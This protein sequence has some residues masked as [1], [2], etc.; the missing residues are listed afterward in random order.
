VQFS[1]QELA[2]GLGVVFI[3]V[4]MVIFTILT[5]PGRRTTPLERCPI[6]GELAQWSTRSTTT[7]CNYGHFSKAD[8]KAHTWWASCR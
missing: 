6:D 1:R 3:A 2:V 4:I 7:V 5:N 8:K